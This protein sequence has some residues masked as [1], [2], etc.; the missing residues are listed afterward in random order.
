MHSNQSQLSALNVEKLNH[1][2]AGNRNGYAPGS[3]KKA[4][5]A[6]INDAASQLSVA[7][8]N[9]KSLR[10]RAIPSQSSGM[11]PHAFHQRN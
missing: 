6:Q 10:M 9:P 4:I 8:R 5:M 11:Q 2:A 7:T 3:N 1:A